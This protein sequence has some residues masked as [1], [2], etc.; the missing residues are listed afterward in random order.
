MNTIDLR[1][2]PALRKFLRAQPRKANQSAI[3]RTLIGVGTS[4]L[5][6]CE[7][8]GYAACIHKGM[9]EELIEMHHHAA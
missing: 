3:A 8:E 4:L 7:G 9:A 6:D 5:V 2:L 1:F